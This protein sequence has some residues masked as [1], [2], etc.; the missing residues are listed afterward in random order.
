MDDCELDE[1]DWDDSDC[2]LDEPRLVDDELDSELLLELALLVEMLDELDRL[3]LDSEL[4]A[5]LGDDE[6]DRISNGA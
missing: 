5:E 1:L 4:D 3:L 2:E 6:L